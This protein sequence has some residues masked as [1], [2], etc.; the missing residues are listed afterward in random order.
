MSDRELDVHP[1]PSQLRIGVL[2]GVAAYAVG[3]LAMVLP[4]P[5][6]NPGAFPPRDVVDASLNETQKRAFAD[7]Q[8]PLSETL[9]SFSSAGGLFYN[10]H[11]VDVILGGGRWVPRLRSNVLLA[12]HANATKGFEVVQD[13]EGEIVLAG[14]PIPPVLLFAVPVVLLAAG[15]FLINERSREALPTPETAVAS[16]S[17]VVLGYLPPAVI[18]ASM[19]RFRNPRVLFGGI[20]LV[21]AVL[22]AGIVYPVA[23][24]GLGGYVW[25]AWRRWESGAS[26]SGSDDP[27]RSPAESAT[28]ETLPE[29]DRA[30]ETVVTTT[31][32]VVMTDELAFEPATVT[33]APG[34]TVV[35]END[36]GL[37]F[38]VTAYEEGI[39]AR[40]GYFASGGF[41]TEEDAR[42]AYPEGGLASGESHRHTFE[43]SG[44]YEY[45]CVPQEDAGMVGTI[46]VREPAQRT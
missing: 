24:G 22:L 43:T 45:F 16:G 41:D 8:V 25:H 18:G 10:A 31:E 19:I 26:T 11:F 23:F 44:S 40:A 12:E 39:P 13:S 29:A 7:G 15:G 34:D 2:A 46:E 6:A 32:R 35:W 37:T 20:D 3:F 5:I 17:A 42:E 1:G 21:G 36:A 38:T 9:D 4:G 14:L 30:T 27:P 28:G 33:I